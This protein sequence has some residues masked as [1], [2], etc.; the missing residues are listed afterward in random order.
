MSNVQLRTIRD[1]A[2]AAAILSAS[3]GGS[4]RLGHN[5]YLEYRPERAGAFTG[6]EPIA[7]RFHS[8]DVVIFRPDG[9]AELRTGGWP[10]V[11]TKARLNEYAQ[12]ARVYSERGNLMVA[13]RGDGGRYT[14]PDWAHAV[15]FFDGVRI[16][17]DGQITNPKE[18]PQSIFRAQ[19]RMRAMIMHYVRGY[20][21][22]LRSAKGLPAP[23]NGDCWGCLFRAQD[24]SL[25]PLGTG[26]LS[27]HF[28]DRYYVPSLAINALREA[29]YRDLGI[30]MQL[31]ILP[32][33]DGTGAERMRID[34]TYTATSVARALR[35]YL[36]V[37][38]VDQR[39]VTPRGGVAAQALTTGQTVQM[40]VHR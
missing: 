26:H 16:N 36:T 35:K 6:L 13:P 23:S 21:A 19:D 40:E 12:G 32:S 2:D 9:T 4:A 17:S 33:A 5:T 7:V 29:G 18:A 15:R 1:W 10:T 27:E 25:E 20:V 3:R 34:Q 11:T 31:G 28:R 30:A 8:T 39:N 22:A 38:L 14:P 24:R 37:R